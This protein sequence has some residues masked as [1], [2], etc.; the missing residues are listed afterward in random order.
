MSNLRTVG[1]IIMTEHGGCCVSVCVVLQT[2]NSM[3]LH[4]RVILE[5]PL[6]NS[7]KGQ[8]RTRADEP[9]C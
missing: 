4:L 9:E 2:C 8:P 7:G 5:V 1:P 3:H 6:L